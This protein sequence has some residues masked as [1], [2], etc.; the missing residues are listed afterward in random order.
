MQTINHGH[1]VRTILNVKQNPVMKKLAGLL[2]ASLICVSCLAGEITF[3]KNL[4]WKQI[5]EKA[6]KEK[7]MIFF[8]AF[9]SWCGPCKYLESSVYTDASV[10]AYYNANFIN[11]KFDMEDGEGLQL[12][13]EFGITSY[14]TLLFFSPQGKLVHK[15]IG[16]MEPGDFIDLG[17]DAVDPSKQYFTL[18]EKA[19]QQ[20][21][22]DASFLKWVEMADKMDDDD[23]NDIITA[24]LKSK[25]DLLSNTEIANIALLYA[26]NLTESQVGFLFKNK[27]RINSLSGWNGEKADN[28]LYNILFSR[29]WRA[30]QLSNQE[31]DSFRTQFIKFNPSRLNYAV[32]DL[33][34]RMAIN[35][36]PAKAAM[37]LTDY[38]QNTVEPV[39]L[40]DIAGWI[41]DYSSHFEI[42]N[43]SVIN[44]A[45]KKF[46]FRSIDKD[47]EYWAYLVQLLC[48]I[49]LENEA[50]ARIAGEKAYKHPFLPSEFRE[51]L[52]NSY[53]FG[54]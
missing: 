18:K 12:A 6:A 23:K 53:G 28:A 10:A 47:N 24:F 41:L 15:Y 33:Y 16:A 52:E 36:D 51:V 19:R 9:A 21:L 40:Q 37:L 3:V 7:K 45:F 1:P 32:K 27:S 2:T 13:E 49:K 5:R 34:F 54:K 48:E 46:T 31:L 22:D 39:L 30:Y 26:T 14:P 25:K 44:E 35:E 43:F 20:Q 42:E 4:T 29:G 17:K 11:V 50:A 38:L 8:D